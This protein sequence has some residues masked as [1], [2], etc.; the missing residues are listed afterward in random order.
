M[1]RKYD[2]LQAKLHGIHSKSITTQRFQNLKKITS[3]E[4]LYQSIFPGEIIT[5]PLQQLVLIIEKKLKEQ[6]WQ[7]LQM[8][9][10]YFQGTHPFINALF[11]RYEIDNLKLILNCYF[12]KLSK[13]NKELEPTILQLLDIKK[14]ESFNLANKESIIKILAN[15]PFSF[16][17]D[18]ID[19]IKELF[20]LENRIDQFYYEHLVDSLNYFSPYEKKSLSAIIIEEMNWQNIIWAF[21]I[22]QYYKAPF[23]R[24]HS[25][26]LIQPGVIPI[27]A[28]EKI[29]ELEFIPEETE[30]L[31]KNFPKKYIPIM[32]SAFDQEGELDV[33][34]LE[35]KIIARLDHLYSHYFYKE[36]FNILPIISFI[37]LKKMEYTNIVKLI[38]SIR[39][40]REYQE[41]TF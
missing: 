31:L 12:N 37:Y 41:M 26:F 40:Q 28:L 10:D 32:T 9:A 30:E 38:E 21:R 27:S 7:D 29:F 24:I 19:D 15:T 4:K 2:Y 36:N 20:L 22:K 35:E 8:I 17:I 1:K 14:I 18:E 5:V 3:I 34:Q 23:N 6:V 25:T 39:Y 16:I 13:L 11:L 33:V